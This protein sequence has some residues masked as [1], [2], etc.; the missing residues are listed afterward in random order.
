MTKALGLIAAAGL[1]VVGCAHAPK[2]EAAR[3]DLTQQAQVTL[4]DMQSR[5]P[6][7][8]ALLNSS[9]GYIVFPKVAQGGF[10]VGAGSGKGVVFQNGQPI[11]FATLNRGSVGAQV[12]GQTFAE[13][14]VVRD[15]Y[16]LQRIK[17]GQFNLGAQ[18]SA[19]AITYGASAATRFNN[20]VAVFVQPHGG[21]ELNLSLT[22]QRIKFHG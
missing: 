20:G 11:G 6:N 8:Q 16:T 4:Q 10:I 17:A 5:D 1:L 21:A 22:G 13:L 12:G 18:A 14:I 19:V 2:T 7:L 3:Q 9:A 15:A